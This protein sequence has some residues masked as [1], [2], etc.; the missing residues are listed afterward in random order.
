MTIYPEYAPRYFKMI[1]NATNY[2]VVHNHRSY[3]QG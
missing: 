3:P 1:Q 2:A